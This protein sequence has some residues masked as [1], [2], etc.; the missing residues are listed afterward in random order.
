M[1]GEEIR[2][3]TSVTTVD[4][5]T[6][7]GRVMGSVRY[8]LFGSPGTKRAFQPY[9]GKLQLGS[10]SA[11]YSIPNKVIES[12]VAAFSGEKP[13]VE[14]LMDQ[15]QPGDVFWD[16]GSFVGLLTVLGAHRAKQVI[17]IEPDPGL[18][19]QTR[20]NV[21]LNKL[22]NVTLVE[23]ALGAKEEILSLNTSGEQG[24][25]PSFFAK[26]LARQVEVPVRRLDAL[27]TEVGTPNVLKIDVEGFED[28]VLEGGAVT[29]RHPGLR[30]IFL[31][32]H[33]T[34]LTKNGESFVTPVQRI[35]DAGF[36]VASC[37]L[38]RQEM[39]LVFLR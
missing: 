28:K 38:K 15:I 30:A 12:C 16:V 6:V 31:E 7:A 37:E 13:Y 22:A 1:S 20:S 36:R 4:R 35:L 32:L 29:L 5:R 19:N 18:A 8:H 17:A 10:T 33:P 25:A 27:A 14:R 23:C 9:T 3:I 34:L 26:G 39:M 24:A 2:D 11:L 21:A